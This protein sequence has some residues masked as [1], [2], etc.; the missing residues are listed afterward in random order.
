MV[1]C[2]R[3]I[4]YNDAIGYDRG[5]D[6]MSIFKGTATALIT[7][8]KDDKIDYVSMGRLVQWQLNQGFAAEQDLPAMLAIYSPYVL[9]T[10]YSFEYTPPTL[11]EF[12]HRFRDYTR[13][14][15]WLVWEENGT[16]LGYAYGSRP[17]ERAA[18]QWNAEASIYLCPDQCDGYI[19]PA[20]GS[21][22]VLG[23]VA[24]KI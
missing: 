19:S 24:G 7:P 22:V 4:S 21:E 2:R 1:D 18:Y 23:V 17:F 6:F 3:E 13:Q 15:P 20:S 11:E 10:A 8:F 16:V 5:S 14:F 9:T 12:T